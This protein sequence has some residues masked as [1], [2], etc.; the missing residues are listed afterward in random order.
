[1]GYDFVAVGGD[2]SMIARRSEA[3]L[4]EINAA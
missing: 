2:M 4:A 1:M 3:L